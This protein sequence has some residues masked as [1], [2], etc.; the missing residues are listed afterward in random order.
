MLLSAEVS[1][2]FL[3]WLHLKKEKT[4]LETGEE[5]VG[6]CIKNS[7]ASLHRDGTSRRQVY[8]QSAFKAGFL[9]A[10]ANFV[11][12]LQGFSVVAIPSGDSGQQ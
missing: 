1:F 4:F 11:Q 12:I 3:T 2:L 8:T 9:S 10:S 5:K 7:Q 6:L